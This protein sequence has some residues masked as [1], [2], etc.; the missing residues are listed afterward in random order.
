ME[1]HRM[2]IKNLR[3]L[4]YEKHW[5]PGA[6][7]DRDFTIVDTTTR[8]PKFL[9]PK[10]LDSNMC[11]LFDCLVGEVE[12]DGV[13]FEFKSEPI[14]P[15]PIYFFG[16]RVIGPHHKLWNQAKKDNRGP[17]SRSRIWRSPRGPCYGM[18]EGDMI[19]PTP[20]AG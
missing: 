12:I 3:V 13:W 19:L 14:N 2:N 9:R 16:G 8:D 1:V 6:Y 4:T 17:T 5:W 18:S 11:R 15:S 10:G 7:D 20:T